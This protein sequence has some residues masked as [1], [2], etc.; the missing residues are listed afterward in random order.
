MTKEDREQYLQCK[1]STFEE[2]MQNLKDAKSNLFYA[3]ARV[4]FWTIAMMDARDSLISA[5]AEKED[6]AA[7]TAQE[8]NS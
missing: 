5:I 7:I 4:S 1:R 6:T 8:E 2:A 3:K